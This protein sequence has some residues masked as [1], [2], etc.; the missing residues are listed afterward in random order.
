MIKEIIADLKLHADPATGDLSR[1]RY[2]E[3]G[4]F[5]TERVQTVFGT[6]REARRQAG[7]EPTRGQTALL[8]NI[9]QHV[10]HDDYRQF[11]IDRKDYGE[12]YR[13]PDSKRYQT[14]IVCTDIHDIEA[15]P[16]WV[17]VFLDS[18][19]R[20]QP[21]KL[22]F[23]GDLFDLAEFGRYSVDPRDWNV[24]GRIKWV[25][26]FLKQCRDAAGDSTE[27]VLI[28]GNHEHRLLRHLAEATPA[29]KSIL[30]DLHGFTVPK[31]LGLDE[32]EVRY[33]ARADLATYNQTNVR[34]ELS[35]NYE[36]FYDC[37][38]VDHFPQGASRGV[39]GVN[40]HHHKHIV[41][42]H[43]SHVYG[44]YEWHQLGSGHKRAASYCDGE[45]WTMG[46]ATVHI[47][48]QE[49]RSVV[50]YTDVRDFAVVGGKF[51]VREPQE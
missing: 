6:W 18:C 50:D 27:F 16:F 13:R 42:S 10:S 41:D 37:F 33:V 22:V 49:K 35:K 48:T 47:D 5:S 31:L 30:S 40:G 43:Y 34:H 51:Y 25:H 17:R 20:I 28:E 3:V 15:D 19:R 21:S 7:L 8:N 12:K 14:I 9:A 24:V 23:G 2:R 44:A 46:F 26:N 11:A 36:V 4:K 45:K 29:L 1:S 38:L 39:P 32:F